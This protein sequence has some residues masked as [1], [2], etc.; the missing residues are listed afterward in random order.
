M[1]YLTYTSELYQGNYYLN[2]ARYIMFS[3]VHL[4]VYFAQLVKF[5]KIKPKKLLIKY[6]R[7]INFLI[8][9]YKCSV[10][11]TNKLL[12]VL[13]FIHVDSDCW[14]D[15]LF[16]VIFF[17][18]IFVFYQYFIF[19][20]FCSTS[21]SLVRSSLLHIMYANRLSTRSRWLPKLQ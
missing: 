4:N 17:F 2:Q 1:P 14:F 15:E 20:F 16:L 9:Y 3:N 6:L 8:D 13:M 21:F 18:V 19:C 11:I 7:T 12:I 10:S 5:N